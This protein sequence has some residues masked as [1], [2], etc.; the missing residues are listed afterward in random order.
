M[1]IALAAITTPN[2]DLSRRSKQMFCAMHGYHYVESAPIDTSRH[3]TWS[4]LIVCWQLLMY[5]DAVWIS[6]ADTVIDD[7]NIG[8][9]RIIGSQPN[10]DLYIGPSFEGQ[11]ILRANPVSLGFIRRAWETGGLTDADAF[12]EILNGPTPLIRS[13]L[14][15]DLMFNVR[16]MP[17]LFT[18]K[19]SNA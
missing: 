8:L 1:K 7:P 11:Y 14:V 16:P 15:S 2:A 12:R 19:E 3:Y 6:D 5:F 4:R 13:C 17:P 18:E 10:A 9:D